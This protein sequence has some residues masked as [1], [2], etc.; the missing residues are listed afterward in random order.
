MSI[1]KILKRLWT[2]LCLMWVLAAVPVLCYETNLFP[3]GACT[4]DATT[5][6]VLEV[7]AILLTLAAVP[8]ALKVNG[9]FLQRKVAE[10]NTPGEKLR[11]LLRW[12]EVQVFLLTV[13]VLVDISVYYATMESLGLLCAAV[14][15]VTSLLCLPSKEKLESYLS[16][17]KE[18]QP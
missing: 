9:T 17:P 6:Y 4:G 14:G 10:R 1:K 11:T 8:A 18:K 7:A 3:G 2:E 12:S 16:N 5:A 15:L 13:V